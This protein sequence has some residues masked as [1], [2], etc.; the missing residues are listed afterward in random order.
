MQLINLLRKYNIL[1]DKKIRLFYIVIDLLLV[2]LDLC[3]A[4]LET[5]ECCQN[6]SGFHSLPFLLQIEVEEWLTSLQ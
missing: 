1:L 2:F 4:Q 6:Q 3:V 5:R